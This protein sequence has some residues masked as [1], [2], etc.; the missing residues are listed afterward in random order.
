M[1]QIDKVDNEYQIRFKYNP[2]LIQ[3]IKLIPGKVWH[4]DI[5]CWTLPI[6]K[7]GMFLNVLK[8]TPYEKEIKIHSDE[9]IGKNDTLGTTQEIPE[10]DMS[11]VPFY[12]KEGSKP[13][14]HQLDFMKYAIDRQNKNY[15]T[16]FLCADEQGLGKTIESINLS[17]Y[18]K[19]HMKVKRCLII[20][21]VNS[22]KYNWEKEVSIHTQGKFE[23]YLLGSRS[24]KKRKTREVIDEIKGSAEKLQDLTTL[25]KHGNKSEKTLP[26]FIITNIESLGYKNG[27]VYPMTEAIVDLINKGEIGMIVIDEVHKNCSPTCRQG[28]Q[29]IKIYDKTKGKCIWLPL[30]G[31]PIVNSPLDCYL[32]MKLSGAHNYKSYYE[33]SKHFCVYG[34][35]GGH[36]VIAYKNIPELKLM[37]GRN[38]IRRTKD[39]VLDLPEKIYFNEYVENTTYQKRLYDDM[40]V[41]LLSQAQDI[42]DSMNPMTKFLRLRQINGSPEL[43]D[44][45]LVVDKNYIKCNA[46]LQKVLEILEDIHQRGEK[47]VIFSNWIEPLRTLYRHVAAKYKVC[48]FTGSMKEEER[49]KHKQVFLNNPEY[50]VMLG[51]IGAL[52]TTHT[53]T[54]ANNI[55]FYDEPW[56]YTDKAQAED[57]CH[58]IGTNKSV[59]IYTLLTRN[60]VDDRV[61]DIVYEKKDTAGFIVDGK[62]DFKNNPNLVYK[63]LGQESR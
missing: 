37:M 33:W 40:T 7:L 14:N 27:R 46:K 52:G 41:E 30:T 43:V 39:Q 47:V 13:M 2:E 58:R 63:L 59:N 55:I 21:N 9:D 8:G 38:M 32:P 10:V 3:E 60:T 11:N 22:S 25:R 35:F 1:I 61:H 20:C 44:H 15:R 31:T 17:I 23:A 12:V 50:T 16:G 5:K 24:V 54:V 45:D 19:R 26:F 56:T 42:A 29:I 6:D 4:P 18:N 53:L 51:T 34:G 48:C 36:E 28:K 49:Q 57:R 62:F